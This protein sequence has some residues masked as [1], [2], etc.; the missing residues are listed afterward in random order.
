MSNIRLYIENKLAP[1]MAFELADKQSHYLI[2]VMRCKIGDII[3]CFNGPDGEFLC[4]VENCG[5]K[6]VEVRVQSCLQKAGD[7]RADIWLV[8]APLKKDRTDF[9]IE[10]AVELGA[11]K[12]IPVVTRYTNCERIKPDRLR[13]Q[14]IEAAEQSKRLTIPEITPLTDFSDFLAS[15]DNSREL[16]FMDERRQGAT[17][18]DAFSQSKA[19]AAILI[20]PEGGFSNEEA[21]ML[22]SLDFVTNISLGPRILRAET[23]A[24]SALALWQAIAGDW[25]HSGDGK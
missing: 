22:N 25:Y 5:K 15:Y 17:A 6:N 24:V 20:G 3:T 21:T 18:V 1:D 7:A 16:F 9:L 19:S 23:A 4:Q 2:N 14:A 10:K 13:A 12:L 11:S 8:F